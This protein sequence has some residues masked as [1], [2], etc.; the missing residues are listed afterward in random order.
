M[1][2]SSCETV[3]IRKKVIATP[4]FVESRNTFNVI[5]CNTCSY[6]YNS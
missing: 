2:I 4:G 5:S 6:L 1:M 3:I